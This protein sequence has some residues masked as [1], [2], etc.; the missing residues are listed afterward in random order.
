MWRVGVNKERCWVPRGG[1]TPK[2][3]NEKKERPEIN[4]LGPSIRTV[5]FFTFGVILKQN[6]GGEQ[7]KKK[8]EKKEKTDKYNEREHNVET[9]AFIF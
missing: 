2:C 5:S 3:A 8:S 6:D 9:F 4:K 1:K 7:W